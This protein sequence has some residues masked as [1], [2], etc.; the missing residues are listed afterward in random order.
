MSTE[1][2][3]RCKSDKKDVYIHPCYPLWAGTGHNP[4][5]D[6]SPAP[7][8]QAGT[9]VG[10]PV[11]NVKACAHMFKPNESRCYLCGWKQPGA[12]P[13][14]SLEPVGAEQFKKDWKRKFKFYGDAPLSDFHLHALMYDFA[15]HVTASLRAEIERLQS[16]CDE[17]R[18]IQRREEKGEVWHKE[19]K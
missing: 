8:A 6:T 5:H 12:E 4:W 11:S 9:A 17:L 3:P 18:K 2:C 14:P 19:K 1:R 7:Q 13:A 16:D 10:L 15:A